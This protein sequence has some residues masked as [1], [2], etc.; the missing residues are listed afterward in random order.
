MTVILELP[1]QV[2]QRVRA[3]AAARGMSLTTYLE[4]VIAE[5]ANR[6][7]PGDPRLVLFAEW[8]AEDRTDDP[9]EIESRT[10]E[11]EEMKA[12]LPRH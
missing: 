7:L 10:R 5:S 6:Q 3:Q 2:E 9:Q 11:W 8:E 12:N 4:S 1:A